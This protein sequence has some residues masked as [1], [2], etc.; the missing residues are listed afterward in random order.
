MIQNV[1]A[2]LDSQ[3]QELADKLARVDAQ[4]TGHRKKIAEEYFKIAPCLAKLFPDLDES[5]RRKNYEFQVDGHLRTFYTL[6]LQR[7]LENSNHFTVSQA[8]ALIELL[9]NTCFPRNRRL[10]GSELRK[11][12]AGVRAVLDYLRQFDLS[13][14]Q[15]MRLLDEE[16]K[17]KK[18]KPSVEEFIEAALHYDFDMK[19][20][21]KGLH[22][23]GAS[24]K[25]SLGLK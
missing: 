9:R 6:A 7:D 17:N 1:A 3:R 11:I 19:K 2:C 23:H 21:S 22:P 12:Y 5:Y 10:Y 14:S 18:S 4:L 8:L 15:I 24:E 20:Y 16:A 25:K 13:S